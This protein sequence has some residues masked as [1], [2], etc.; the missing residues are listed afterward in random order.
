VKLLN[1]AQSAQQQ[2]LQLHVHQ[3]HHVAVHLAHLAVK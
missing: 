1:L 3:S 2:H